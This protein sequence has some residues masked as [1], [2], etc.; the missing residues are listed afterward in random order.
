M[1]RYHPFAVVGTVQRGRMDIVTKDLGFHT[2]TVPT[3]VQYGWNGPER[4]PQGGGL[5]VGTQVQKSGGGPSKF[6]SDRSQA[7]SVPRSRCRLRSSDSDHLFCPMTPKSSR[8]GG[9]TTGS[10]GPPELSCTF[11]RE[12]PVPSHA[13]G[14][15]PQV[16]R[17]ILSS[18]TVPPLLF[19]SVGPI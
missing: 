1:G 15:F 13:F 7:P 17:V 6:R 9:P 10:V 5:S 19:L 18:P 4:R 8:T 12:G 16:W 2:I 3:D 11:P 14:V